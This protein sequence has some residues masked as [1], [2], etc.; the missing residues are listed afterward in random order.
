MNKVMNIKIF[1]LNPCH[2]IFMI[3]CC[4]TTL[5]VFFY[6]NVITMRDLHYKRKQTLMVE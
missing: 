6:Q 4:L 3:S 2:F 1:L 5:G